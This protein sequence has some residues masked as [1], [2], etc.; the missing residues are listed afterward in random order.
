MT[1]R[2]LL[3]HLKEFLKESGKA[4]FA[5]SDPKRWTKEKDSSTTIKYESGN[6]KF[7]DNFFGGEPYGGRTVVYYK[8]SPVWMFIYYG[9]VEP[10]VAN[11]Q[12]VYDFLKGALNTDSENKMFRG[13]KKFVQNNFT[14]KNSWKGN[15][16][17]FLGKEAIYNK[18]K[19]IYQA[20]YMGGLVDQRKD[21]ET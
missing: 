17:K 12:K 11:I 6:W 3:K 1:K 5:S 18:G 16:G 21:K 2:N 9:W 19:K 4:D 13:P 20:K 8:G 7:N 15:L 14:Y 10:N